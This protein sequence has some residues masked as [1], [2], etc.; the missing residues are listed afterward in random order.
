MIDEATNHIPSKP[1]DRHKLRE[2]LLQ[3]M[4][5]RNFDTHD[6]IVRELSQ[7]QFAALIKDLLHRKITAFYCQTG[8]DFVGLGRNSPKEVAE[9]VRE[10][11]RR[12][13]P[14]REFLM[15]M[16]EFETALIRKSNGFD[17][18]RGSLELSDPML[19]QVV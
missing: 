6:R 3:A 11:F 1:A 12:Q 4:T 8:S 17:A 16:V 15:E 19:E 5:T 2:Q 10:H 13:L 14:I 9:L 18:F 7:G